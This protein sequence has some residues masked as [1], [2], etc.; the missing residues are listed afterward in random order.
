MFRSD[1]SKAQRGRTIHVFDSKV[2]GG[3]LDPGGRLR[4]GARGSEI[5]GRAF[6]RQC[7]EALT[8]EENEPKVRAEVL[9]ER[10]PN[11]ALIGP[12]EM[13]LS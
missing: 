2:P 6:C 13:L 10:F 8:C 3:R 11:I 9:E 5:L 1:K 12:R 7:P 4:I